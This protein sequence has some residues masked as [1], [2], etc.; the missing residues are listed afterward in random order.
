[1]LK[2]L[3]VVGAVIAIGICGYFYKLGKDSEKLSPELGFVDGKFADCPAKP[4]CVSSFADA[5]D[6]THYIA[7]RVDV[8]NSLYLI[9]KMALE[10]GMN[11]VEDK[12]SY[13][14]FEDKSPIFGFIDDV[15][16]YYIEK[17]QTLHYRSASRVGHSDMSANRR[18]LKKMLKVVK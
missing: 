14:R 16:F 3:V 9:K 10:N 1:M 6:E 18:R 2:G 13:M 4:N 5:A 17:E 15:E 8:G 12:G 11:I 7:P